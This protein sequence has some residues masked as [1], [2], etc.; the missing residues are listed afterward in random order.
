[1]NNP[2]IERTISDKLNVT[3]LKGWIA[4][5]GTA[6]IAA[7]VSNGNKISCN[8]NKCFLLR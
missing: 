3:G 8:V 4:V 5:A 6:M 2:M 1:M 7:I